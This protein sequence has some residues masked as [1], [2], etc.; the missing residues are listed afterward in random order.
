MGRPHGSLQVF[1]RGRSPPTR[2]ELH[3]A[4]KGDLVTTVVKRAFAG[5]AVIAGAAAV[6][7]EGAWRSSDEPGDRNVAGLSTST[8]REPDQA[9]QALAFS[10]S[11]FPQQAAPPGQSPG[12]KAPTSD[13]WTF[14]PAHDAFRADSLLDLRK[15]NETT[16]G[17]SG[18]VRLSPDKNSFVTGD[19]Q[20]IRFWAVHFA[21]AAQTRARRNWP[22]PPGS[23][24]SVA[25]TWFV[26][27]TTSWHQ[28]GIPGSP[29]PT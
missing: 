16:A 8:P 4:Q 14:R 25:S 26:S 11:F 17:Q 18:F 5:L 27:W 29:T 10:G 7:T 22:T 23:W 20:P 9:S 3:P 15:L 12:T 28:P 19:G 24:P 1:G 6:V 2:P 13:F 21:P